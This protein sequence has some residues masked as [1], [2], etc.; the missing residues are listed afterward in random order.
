MM[1]ALAFGALCLLVSYIC[2]AHSLFSGKERIF[3]WPNIVT[4]LIALPG[5]YLTL[6]M[7]WQM[8]K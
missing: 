8:L 6:G 3:I 5:T 1:F 4:I 7:L 2:L